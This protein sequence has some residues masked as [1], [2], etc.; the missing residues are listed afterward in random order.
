M[1]LNFQIPKSA[2]EFSHPGMAV[3]VA[4]EV[5]LLRGIDVEQVLSQCLTNSKNFYNLHWYGYH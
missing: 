1:N 5:A 2:M 4:A 3:T